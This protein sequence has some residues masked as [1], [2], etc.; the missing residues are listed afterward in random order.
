MLIELLVAIP[1]LLLIYG[2]FFIAFFTDDQGD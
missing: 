1:V 2:A